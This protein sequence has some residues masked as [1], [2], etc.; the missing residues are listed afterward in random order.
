MNLEEVRM[1]LALIAAV[2]L[3]FVSSCYSPGKRSTNAEDLLRQDDC[4]SKVFTDCRPEVPTKTAHK[5]TNKAA[6]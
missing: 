4:L 1:K 6:L 2:A 3:G 5:Q